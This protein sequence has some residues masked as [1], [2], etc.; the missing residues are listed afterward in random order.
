VTSHNVEEMRNAVIRGPHKWPGATHVQNEDGTLVNLEA[1]G[2]D[3]RMAVASQ[4]ITPA[5]DGES[6]GAVNKKVI[7]HIRNGMIDF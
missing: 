6:V 2:E 1:I 7:R 3:G 5:I 4:L